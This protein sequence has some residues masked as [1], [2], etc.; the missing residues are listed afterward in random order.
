MK[1]NA[2]QPVNFSNQVL[3]PDAPNKDQQ[4]RI[5]R[6]IDWLDMMNLTWHS[7]PSLQPYCYYLQR[8][9]KIRG[10]EMDGLA[11]STINA[12][13]STIRSRYRALVNDMGIRSQLMEATRQAASQSDQVQTFADIKGVV[14][15]IYLRLE[16]GIIQSAVKANETI[17]QDTPD[18]EFPRLTAE[19]AQ[20]LLSLPGGRTLQGKRDTALLGLMLTTGIRAEEASSL[21]VADLRQTFGGELSLHIRHGKGDKERLIPYGDMDWILVV[22]EDWLSSASITFGPVFR[23]FYKGYKKVR[24]GALSTRAIQDIVS[25]YA[26]SIGGHLV[27]LTPHGL[28][29]SYARILFLAG[30]DPGKIKQNMGHENIQTTFDYI[31]TLDASDRRPPNAV[32]FDVASYLREAPPTLS[33][34]ER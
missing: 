21:V 30:M 34:P 8:E 20:E 19:Q 14:D 24:K 13:L 10:D 26:V 2:L 25:S 12:H 5:Q 3:M 23:G 6:F 17:S 16:R 28:R 15:E 1:E 33:F 9:G 22:V 27:A 4:S 29:R 7:I 11:P 31:G 32:F 18:S